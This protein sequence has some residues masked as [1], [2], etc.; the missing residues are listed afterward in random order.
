MFVVLEENNKKKLVE[1]NQAKKKYVCETKN[2]E[3]S[4]NNGLSR[5]YAFIASFTLCVRFS[6]GFVSFGKLNIYRMMCVRECLPFTVICF[7]DFFSSFWLFFF[8]FCALLR[9][10]QTVNDFNEVPWSGFDSQ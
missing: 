4:E 7:Y 6:S 8:L 1:M 9:A 2:G 3:P 5:A 10:T